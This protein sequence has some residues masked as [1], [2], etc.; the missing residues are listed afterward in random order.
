M[1]MFGGTGSG[2]GLAPFRPPAR[3]GGSPSSWLDTST[4]SSQQQRLSPSLSSS[5]PRIG[6]GGG[7]AAS[8]PTARRNS[9]AVEDYM[10]LLQQLRQ[11]EQLND[12]LLEEARAQQLRLVL[13][14]RSSTATTSTS[15]AAASSGVDPT[16][17]Q[18]TG[19]ARQREQ[20]QQEQLALLQQQERLLR[21]REQRQQQQQQLAAASPMAAA[22]S[23]E[24]AAPAVPRHHH[25]RPAKKRAMHP[26]QSPARPPPS[27]SL[28]SAT[29]ATDTYKPG[30]P[31]ALPTDKDKLTMYQTLIRASLE[32]F[33][34]TQEDINTTVQGRRQKLLVGQST[35]CAT[36]P[37]PRSGS[38]LSLFVLLLCYYHMKLH[39]SQ[40]VLSCPY[41]LL[42]CRKQKPSTHART[43]IRTPAPMDQS[44]FAAS[45]VLIYRWDT[46]YA[47]RAR[48]PIPKPGSVFVRIVVPQRSMCL[49]L[50]ISHAMHN[51]KNLDL[52]KTTDQAAQNIAAAHLS[53]PC[54]FMPEDMQHRMEAERHKKGASK[55]GQN[56]WVKACDVRFVIVACFALRSALSSSTG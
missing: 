11:Q 52:P 37:Q 4:S 53:K 7:A 21:S 24:M 23:D 3:L 6:G 51:P 26:P 27:S 38:R 17:G 30:I 22:S 8:D 41:S 33:T 42:C 36:P 56:Y 10:D 25:Q 40:P 14:N 39:A 1:T 45:F 13:Q 34:A 50:R 28:R 19:T 46:C 18:A 43:N 12:R 2:S 54:S 31:L 48:V 5:Y 44:A 15:A 49:Y 55:A 47:A 9:P 32:Y 35:C 20:R 16:S 29:A